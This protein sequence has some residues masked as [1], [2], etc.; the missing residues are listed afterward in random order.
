[1]KKLTAILL[2]IASTIAARANSYT[3]IPCPADL[4]DLSHS[5]AYTWGI[6]RTS[7]AIGATEN[8][9]RNQLLSG[10]WKISSIKLSITNIYNWDSR[11]TDNKLFIHVLDNPRTGV[12]AYVDDPTDTG[13]NSGTVSD[14]FGGIY[15]TANGTRYYGSA[16]YSDQDAG[17]NEN[18]Y[19]TQYHDPLGG[20]AN[21]VNLMFDFTSFASTFETY[22]ENG[23]SGGSSYADFGLGFDPDCHYYNDKVKLC[24]TTTQV[25]D[26]GATMIMLGAGLLA[27]CV[28]A[29]FVRRN[30]SKA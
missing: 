14:F 18:T 6:S 28:A 11:D 3:F 23:A 17:N 10:L 7:G 4:S 21:R 25:P 2:A 15:G 1:M 27:L 12:K 29:M 5:Y 19:L 20:W 13:I 8:D 22:I 9:L 26:S 30:Q 24:I 16:T